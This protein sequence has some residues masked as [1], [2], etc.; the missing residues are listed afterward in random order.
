MINPFATPQN[1]MQNLAWRIAFIATMILPW[2]LIFNR[3]T[4]EICCVLIGLLFLQNSFSK[5]RWEWASDPVVVAG[6]CAWAWIVAVVSP[7]A[8][9]PAASFSV[10]LPWGRYILL[11]AAL[12]YWVLVKSEALLLLGKNLSAMLALVISD[13]LWQYVYGVSLTGHPRLDSGRLTGPLDN[14]K[15]GIFMAKILLP[16]VGMMLFL[17]ADKKKYSWIAAIALLFVAG[18]ITILLSGE[19]T[20]FVSS[21]IGLAVMIGLLALAERR[22]RIAAPFMA[23]LLAALVFYMLRTQEWVLK[24]AHDLTDTIYS[25]GDSVYGRLFKA[26]CIIGDDNWLHGVGIKGFRVVSEGLKDSVGPFCS[27]NE[28]CNLH[29]HNTYLEWF[30]ETGAAGLLFYSA[31]VVFMV[32]AIVR[33]FRISKGVVLLLPAVAMGSVFINFFPVMVTQSIFSNWPAILLWYSIGIGFSSLNL[34]ENSC[35]R[36]VRQ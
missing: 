17:A 27:G 3:A 2:G 4:A 10:A 25:F 34:C 30:S 13:T 6:F 31:M 11:F 9:S 16:T 29:P 18:E 22:V 15:V 23:V 14:V 8:I 35:V 1:H 12:R 19:R 28:L 20:A 26:A 36:P 5:K 21:I 32:V 24:R 33:Y 7:L